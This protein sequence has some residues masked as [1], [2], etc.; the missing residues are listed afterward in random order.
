MNP[1]EKNYWPLGIL[2]VLLLGVF[3]VSALVVVAIKNSPKDDNSYL[4]KHTFTDAHINTMI[5]NYRTFLQSY[6]LI[7]LTQDQSL[8]PL[9]PYYL[10]QN[11]PILWLKLQDNR[12][13]IVI[14][15]LQ[16]EAT[17]LD[18]SVLLIR[19]RDD[20]QPF[21]KPECLE[22]QKQITCQLHP[23]NLPSEGHCKILVRVKFRGDYIPLIQPAYVRAKK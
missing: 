16:P 7:L 10:N 21:S 18:L 19:D 2:A 9:F 5:A 1:K 13:R 8:T 20:L 4:E 6:H 23:F 14:E 22:N 15:K 3:L 11:T 12:V 17:P